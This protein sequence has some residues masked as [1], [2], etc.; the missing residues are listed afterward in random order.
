MYCHAVA[1]PIPDSLATAVN[2]P[3][4]AGGSGPEAPA[5]KDSSALGYATS[6][7]DIHPLC[8][9]GYVTATNVSHPDTGRH[10]ALYRHL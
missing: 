9:L 1:V 7:M 5:D 8:P 10:R 6:H 2:V 4:Y 3:S